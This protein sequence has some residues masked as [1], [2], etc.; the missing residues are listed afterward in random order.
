LLHP[1]ARDINFYLMSL[2]NLKRPRIMTVSH[3]KWS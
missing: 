1:V 3:A 2:A